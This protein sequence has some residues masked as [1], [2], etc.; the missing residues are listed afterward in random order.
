MKFRPVAGVA[1]L[2]LG[3]AMLAGGTLAISVQAM[4]QDSS[5]RLAQQQQ[6]QRPGLPQA[7]QGQ[8]GGFG[9]FGGPGGPGGPGGFGGPGFGGPGMMMGG[10]GGGASV[11]ATPDSVYVLRGNSL[12][13]FDSRTLKL[14]A[15]AELPRPEMRPGGQGFPGQSGGFPQ[16][17]GGDNG[18]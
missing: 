13:A 18:Q 7:Q 6:Q 11:T 2:T 10:G 14:R 5:T 1:G 12:Y 16:R 3:A 9:G 17:P 4:A 8:Q 15:Q